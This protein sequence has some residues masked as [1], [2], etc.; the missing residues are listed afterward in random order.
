MFLH[1]MQSSKIN[2]H[3]FAVEILIVLYRRD[4][5]KCN[6]SAY[7]WSPHKVQRRLGGGDLGFLGSKRRAVTQR[8][9]FSV[10][11]LVVADKELRYFFKQT[12]AK[13]F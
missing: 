13:V 10:A 6:G 8:L 3:K 5:N 4:P 11:Q 9:E 12:R 1:H 7:V 2:H